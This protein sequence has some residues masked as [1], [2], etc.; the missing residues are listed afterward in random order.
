MGDRLTALQ[1]G[2]NIVR[3]KQSLDPSTEQ[4]AVDS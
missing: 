3:A 2:L 1:E 4:V